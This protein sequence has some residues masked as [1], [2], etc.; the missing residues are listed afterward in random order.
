M[1]PVQEI[2]RIKLFMPSGENGETISTGEEQ[3]FSS[4]EEAQL[5]CELMT[6][7]LS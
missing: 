5:L 4:H 3:F 6:P 2:Q 1:I 7:T